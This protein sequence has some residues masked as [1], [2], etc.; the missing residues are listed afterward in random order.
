MKKAFIIFSIVLLITNTSCGRKSTEEQA[1]A[2]SIAA[3]AAADSVAAVEAANGNAL[4]ASYELFKND[5]YNGSFQQFIKLLAQNPDALNDMYTLYSIR[6]GYT[7]DLRSYLNLIRI[8]PQASDEELRFLYD[9]LLEAKILIITFEEFSNEWNERPEYRE[10][11][12]DLVYRKNL[13]WSKREI[14][15]QKYYFNE[16]FLTN[17]YKKLTYYDRT[18]SQDVSFE[19]FKLKMQEFEYAQKIYDWL[20]SNDSNFSNNYSAEYYYKKLQ[21]KSVFKSEVN[22][23][24]NQTP[25]PTLSSE[26]VNLIL[27]LIFVLI[28]IGLIFVFRKKLAALFTLRKIQDYL[29][30]IIT[31]VLLVLGIFLLFVSNDFRDEDF[32]FA[33]VFNAF[34]ILL[35]AAFLKRRF[36]DFI[37]FFVALGGLSFGLVLFSSGHSNDEMKFSIALFTTS[38]FI[39]FILWKDNFF[40]KEPRNKTPEEIREKGKRM[41]DELR[42][43]GPDENMVGKTVIKKASVKMEEDKNPTEE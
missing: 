3:A 9:V 24:G 29:L 5:G 26:E 2:D 11:V 37:L 30:L 36:V 27:G 20:S 22:K 31:L 38:I 6:K 35:L 21:I 8:E 42:E 23:D 34:G 13:Y 18:Y 10:E 7:G 16:V 4:I 43:M 40:T 19:N 12:F 41:L 1:L 17:L 25:S 33:V 39:L 15:F 28:G 14:F 32:F